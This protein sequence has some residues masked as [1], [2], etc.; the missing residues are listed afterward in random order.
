MSAG[1]HAIRVYH[2]ARDGK[3]SELPP[4]QTGLDASG[5]GVA[6]AVGDFDN[7]GKNDLAVA[8]SDRVLLFR[9]LGNGK[10]ADVTKTAGIIPLNRPFWPDV[11]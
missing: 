4:P 8:L 1:E 9:N 6:C 2:D 3:W 5:T 7:D 10:F 11:C